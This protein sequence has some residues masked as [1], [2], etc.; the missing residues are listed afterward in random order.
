MFF[1]DHLCLTLY[2]VHCILYIIQCTLFI[3]HCA[4]Y[5][6]HYSS[7]S[8]FHLI[9]TSLSHTFNLSMQYTTFTNHFLSLYIS[10]YFIIKIVLLYFNRSLPNAHSTS[11]SLS[12]QTCHII[13]VY[14]RPYLSPPLSYSITNSLNLYPPLSTYLSTSLSLSLSLQSNYPCPFDI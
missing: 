9:H 3:V 2:S 5:N 11:L 1:Y 13:S 7:L 6:V 10:I 8:T 12:L 4:K 14:R